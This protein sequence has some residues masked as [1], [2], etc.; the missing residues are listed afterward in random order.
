MTGSK[1][2]QIKVAHIWK[3]GRWIG[4]RQSIAKIQEDF[5]GGEQI[6]GSLDM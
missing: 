5:G 1:V 4:V 6:E 3:P 2:T